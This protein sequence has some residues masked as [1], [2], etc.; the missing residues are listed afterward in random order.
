MTLLENEEMRAF[1]EDVAAYVLA[2][3]G[4]EM[5]EAMKDAAIHLDMI[6]ARRVA[7]MGDIKDAFAPNKGARNG[8]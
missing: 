3:D 2:T 1:F 4:D 6:I 5:R 7:I 8:S